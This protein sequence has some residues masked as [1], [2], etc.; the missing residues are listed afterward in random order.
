MLSGAYNDGQT[1]A[2]TVQKISQEKVTGSA[3]VVV[4]LLSDD[5]GRAGLGGHWQTCTSA[6]QLDQQNDA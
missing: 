1:A 3:L 4:H 6:V 2:H 5:I